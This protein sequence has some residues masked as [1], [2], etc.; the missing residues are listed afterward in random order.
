MPWPLQVMKTGSSVHIIMYRLHISSWWVD[1]ADVTSSLSS[2]LKSQVASRV[3]PKNAG[4]AGQSSRSRDRLHIV[5][6]RLD[7]VSEN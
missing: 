6:K 7:K 3:S 1:P 2:E 5:A 4:Q